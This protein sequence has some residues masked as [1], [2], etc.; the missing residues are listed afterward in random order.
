MPRGPGRARAPRGGSASVSG[1]GLPYGK[2]LDDALD[3]QILDLADRP[4]RIEALGAHVHAIHDRVATEQ[5]VRIF[6]VVEPLPGRLV[7]GVGDDAVGLEQARRPDELV[8]VP[9]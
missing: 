9:P 3:E 5:A 6:Q 8:G 1:R 7:A 2:L 4:R